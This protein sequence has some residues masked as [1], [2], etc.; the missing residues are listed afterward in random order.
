M[1]EVPGSE[2]V[3][4]IPTDFWQISSQGIDFPVLTDEEF[5]AI[6]EELKN[7]P[8]QTFGWVAPLEEFAKVV[9]ITV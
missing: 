7:R 3:M 9:A 5:D 8:R 4:R 1:S 2:T 6:A